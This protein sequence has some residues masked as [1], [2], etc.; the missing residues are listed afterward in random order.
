MCRFGCPM[1]C[2]SDRGKEVDG[3][4][5]REICCL[6]D[7]D[8]FRATAYHPSC[9]GVVERFHAT[10]IALLGRAI[11]ENQ[12]SWDLAIPY[13]LAAYRASTHESTGM[14]P[15]FVA[16]G[17]KCTRLL[18]WFTHHLKRSA[19]VVTPHMPARRIE[20][21][22]ATCAHACARAT[23]VAAVRSKRN[24]DMPVRP[25]HYSVGQWEYYFNPRK[26]QG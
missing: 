1:A 6:L 26:I 23:R 14:T 16:T 2:I 11:D 22:D 17:V 7:V 24:Y 9:N 3:K 25:Q 21:S 4:L 12:S 19:Q 13:V 5:M 15:N 20:R 18:T 8:K 10:L